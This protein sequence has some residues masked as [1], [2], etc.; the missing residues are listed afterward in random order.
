MKINTENQT[1]PGG[2]LTRLVRRLTRWAW[3]PEL[4]TL[5]IIAPEQKPPP[6]GKVR[7][8]CAGWRDKNM[9][10]WGDY[11][12]YSIHPTPAAATEAIESLREEH[13]WGDDR[14]PS[15]GQCVDVFFP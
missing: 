2:C 8:Y 10:G 11:Y 13:Q 1:P 9:I 12:L 14:S 3:T 15:C 5:A 6:Q 7:M 4:N